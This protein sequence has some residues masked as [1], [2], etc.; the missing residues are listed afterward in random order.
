MYRR[1]VDELNGKLLSELPSTDWAPDGDTKDPCAAM[2]D[3]KSRP[4]QQRGRTCEWNDMA[5]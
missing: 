1:T 5:G 4:M 3:A 2:A